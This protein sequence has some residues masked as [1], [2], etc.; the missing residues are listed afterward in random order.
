RLAGVRLRF[1]RWLRRRGGG[2]GEAAAGRAG[3]A[4]ASA[5]GVRVIAAAAGAA[6]IAAAAA[7][8]VPDGGPKGP[9]NIGAGRAGAAAA[10]HA[11]DVV[12]AAAA[13]PS[14]QQQRWLGSPAGR[15]VN[16]ESMAQ[17]QRAAGGHVGRRDAPQASATEEEGAELIEAKFWWHWRSSGIQNTGRSVVQGMVKPPW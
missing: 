9:G 5:C 16:R 11:A 6:A 15:A 13:R 8:G 14:Q 2:L 10:R 3:T 12:A 1:R 7:A 17:G 4:A